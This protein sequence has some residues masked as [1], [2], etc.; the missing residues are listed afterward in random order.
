M[1]HQRIVFLDRNAIRVPLRRPSFPHLWRDYPH[2][3]PD[4]TIARLRD[5]DGGGATIAITNRVHVGAAILHEVPSLR[6]VAVA[7]TGYDHVEV[8]ACRDHGVAVCNVRNWAVSVPEHVFALALAL[9]RQL[10]AYQAAVGQ[11]GWQASPT[12][13]MLL[14]PLP[15][16]LAGSTLGVIGYGALGRRV[17][18][19]A[20]CFDMAVL[21]AEHKGAAHVREGRVPFQDVLA[22]SDVLVVLCPLTGETTNLIGAAELALMRPDALLINCARGGIVDEAA[23]ATALA[24]GT[25]GGAGVDVLSEEPPKHGNP[26]LTVCLPNLIVT[27]HVAWASLESLECL[28]EQLIGT[29]EAFV[30]GVPRNLVA[31]PDRPGALAPC[32]GEDVR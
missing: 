7:A 8:A 14:D 1:E 28:A 25:I 23:L 13:T 3:P 26:L 32:R 17:Q 11:G 12:Y 27:P 15:R 24:Q 20:H 6:L 22:R 29:L 31:T 19:L 18:T 16:A 21:I 4:Q 10:P 30:A 5:V 2:T 9:R